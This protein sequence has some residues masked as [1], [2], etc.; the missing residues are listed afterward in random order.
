MKLSKRKARQWINLIQ[1]QNRLG[2]ENRNNSLPIIIGNN[3]NENFNS[4]KSKKLKENKNIFEFNKTNKDNNIKVLPNIKIKIRE[5][6]QGRY[7]YN[8]E[9]NINKKIP[10]SNMNERINNFRSNNIIKIKE[11]KENS[12]FS[13]LKRS[14]ENSSNFKFCISLFNKDYKHL[15]KDNNKD[16]NK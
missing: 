16:N 10:N 5:P 15:N 3:D 8:H 11:N 9:I 14:S 4:E 2:I 12:L 7:F 6:K 13:S 1:S